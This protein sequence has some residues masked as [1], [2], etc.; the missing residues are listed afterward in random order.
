[1]D[2][3][4]FAHWVAGNSGVR[5]NIVRLA[6]ESVAQEKAVKAE[7]ELKGHEFDPITQESQK[8]Q[9]KNRY[10]GHS[11]LYDVAPGAPVLHP[12]R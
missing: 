11:T 1:M 2:G 6:G 12:K 9:V 7:E 4:H 3:K 5:S 10:L 8:P